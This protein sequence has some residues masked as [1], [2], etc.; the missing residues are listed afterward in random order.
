MPEPAS[1][2]SAA[3][4]TVSAVAKFQPWKTVRRHDRL[5]REEY[6]DLATWARDDLQ[7][8]AK[9]LEDVREEMNQRNLLYSGQYGKELRRVRDEFA[10]R[11]RDRK[12]SADRK[13]EAMREE[14]GVSVRLWRWLTKKPWPANPD[15]A[16]LTAMTAAWDDEDARREAVARE[17]ERIG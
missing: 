6:E 1:I 9:A 12:R 10:V 2:V 17:V 7:K 11:W 14:E 8:E 4:K 3:A 13:L 15:A 16:E 5:I